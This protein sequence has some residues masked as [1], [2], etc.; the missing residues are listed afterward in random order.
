M[1]PVLAIAY[2]ALLFWPTLSAQVDA[3][4]ASCA[5]VEVTDG[6][7]TMSFPDGT[8][9][10]GEFRGGQ[11]SGHGTIR[12]GDGAT[13]IG[14]FT[15]LGVVQNAVYVT[16]DGHRYAGE[17]KTS[18]PDLRYPR[19]PFHFPFWRA[20]AKD[21]ASIMVFVVVDESGKVIS[22]HILNPTG[23][24]FDDSVLTGVAT[25]RF[26]PA[27]VDGHPV[28]DIGGARVDFSN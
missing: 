26:I 27:T 6:C 2:G 4:Q 13:M 17:Y 12:F 28:K 8:K 1:R 16:A 7:G 9:Y 24:S 20:F 18:L 5:G 3:Q 19:K 15:E 11:P 21:S 22:A 25:W 14:D 23:K 10:Q